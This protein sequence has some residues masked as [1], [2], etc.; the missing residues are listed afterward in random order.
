MTTSDV[1]GPTERCGPD[2]AVDDPSCTAGFRRVSGFPRA[3]GP[4][5]TPP[6][7]LLRRCDA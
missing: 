3:R 2:T 7:G 1:R 6:G 4:V 5:T